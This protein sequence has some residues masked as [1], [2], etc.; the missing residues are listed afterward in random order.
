MQTIDDTGKVWFPGTFSPE[1]AVRVG[2]T[3]LVPGKT[4]DETIHCWVAADALCVDC[5]DPGNQRRTARRLP[6]SLPAKQ[7]ATL[8]AGFENTQHAD[9]AVI[10]H[11][12]AGVEEV[13]MEGEDYRSRSLGTL[14]SAAFWRLAFP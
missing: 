1:Y 11:R 3:V 13:V 7:K 10:T 6:L 9:V 8:F 5:H 4:E 12:D 2:N 14:D